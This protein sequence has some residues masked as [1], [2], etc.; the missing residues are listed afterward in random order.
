M[1]DHELAKAVLESCGYKLYKDLIPWPPI[2]TSLDACREVFEKDAPDGY[3]DTLHTVCFQAGD[4]Q[5]RIGMLFPEGKNNFRFAI[6]KATPHQRCEAWLR[7]K[8]ARG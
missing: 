3:W 6:A 1:T 4:K 5:T 2:L 8:E 7:F